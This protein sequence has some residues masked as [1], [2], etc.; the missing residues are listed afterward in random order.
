MFPHTAWE[1]PCCCFESLFEK[2]HYPLARAYSEIYTY[3]L[4][5]YL[6]ISPIILN[7][8]VCVRSFVCVCVCSN[9]IKEV[10]KKWLI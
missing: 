2:K 3:F 10:F 7:K 6:N 4:D 9:A 1:F 8:Y 5:V